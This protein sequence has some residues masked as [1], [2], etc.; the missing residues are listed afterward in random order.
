MVQ[1]TDH[2]YGNT[3]TAALG[4]AP[5]LRSFW[6]PSAEPERAAKRRSRGSGISRS[7]SCTRRSD[8]EGTMRKEFRC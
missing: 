8:E 2:S 6:Q 4:S 7:S 1:G 3:R 5:R